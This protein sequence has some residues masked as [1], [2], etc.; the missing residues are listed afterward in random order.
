MLFTRYKKGI[1]LIIVLLI[2]VILLIAI[3]I[4]STNPNILSG[5]KNNTEL[6]KLINKVLV[7]K[8]DETISQQKK[9]LD[10]VSLLE[11]LKN[12]KSSEESQYK[13][14]E[15]AAV[16]LELLYSNTND[17]RLQ[18]IFSQDIA[19]YAEKNYPK[20]YDKDLFIYPCQDPSCAQKPPPEKLLQIIES[21][22]KTDFQDDI[23]EVISRDLMNANYR[24]EQT[25]NAV[26]GKVHQY[27]LVAR[28]I[29]GL[30][31]YTKTEANI[32]INQEIKDFLQADYPNAYAYFKQFNSVLLD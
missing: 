5:N 4:L 21:I 22:K 11:S 16:K 2:V 13:T 31:E 27:L 9:Y 29:K 10:A 3:F 7:L 32:K 20:Y 19:E 15:A 14:L 26:K 23:K 18:K 6:D 8:D 30:S 28:S 24:S 1:A 12:S 17:P 25:E